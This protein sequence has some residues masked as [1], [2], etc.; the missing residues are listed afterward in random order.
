[1]EN[2]YK[3][4]KRRIL[5]QKEHRATKK[6]LMVELAGLDF[7]KRDNYI[8]EELNMFLPE[9]HRKSTNDTG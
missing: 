8:D 7:M 9:R 3:D 5:T 4:G 2:S 1:M 6:L